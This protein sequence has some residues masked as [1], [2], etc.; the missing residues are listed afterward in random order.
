M[1]LLNPITKASQSGY[2]APIGAE[3]DNIFLYKKVIDAETGIESQI[4][5]G[6]LTE[7]YENWI[8][9]KTNANFMYTGNADP[10]SVDQIKVWY[11]TY[12]YQ[13]NTEEEEEEPEE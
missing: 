3:S 2:E 8:D 13:Q 6:T 10:R 5:L 7:F 4:Y 9:F 11:Q 1:T 12:D